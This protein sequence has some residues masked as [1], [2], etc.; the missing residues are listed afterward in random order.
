M[1]VFCGLLSLT[2]WTHEVHNPLLLAAIMGALV[3][4]PF[5]ALGTLFG[6]PFRGLLLGVVLVALYAS[7]IAIAVITG[8]IRLG[9]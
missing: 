5:I 1:A 7:V 8:W 9:C 4:S 3:L 6:R 2:S